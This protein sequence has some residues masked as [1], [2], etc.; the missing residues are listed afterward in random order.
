MSVTI[1][2]TA[3]VLLPLAAAS[4]AGA[5]AVVARPTAAPRAAAAVAV[6][7]AARPLAVYRF[8]DAREALLPTEVTVGDSAGT[9][10][11]HYRLAGERAVRP[12]AVTVIGS[13]LVLQ[14]EAPAGLLTLV[15]DRQNG[16][17]AEGMLSGRWTLGSRSGALRG[18]TALARAR[19]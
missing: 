4:A 19:D 12:L 10:V 7:A 5:Q 17:A 11:A 6:R 14:A 16:D 9:L 18:R 15:L 2:R 13:D 8:A 1:T 3:A